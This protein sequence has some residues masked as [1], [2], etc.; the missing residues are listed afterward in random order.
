MSAEIP[1]FDIVRAVNHGLLPRH[2]LSSRPGRLLQAYVGDYLK[3]EIAAESL[4]RNLPAFSRFLEVAA[5]SNGELV[6]YNNIASEC[7]ISAPSVKEYFEITCDTLIGRFLPAWRKTGKRRRIHAPK[8][9]FFDV[10][11][12]AHLA[13]RGKIEQGSELF[14]RVF[15]QFMINEIH[16]HA[17]YSELFYPRAFWRSASGF[18][19]DC[20]L[21][22]H[23]V[24]VEF[25]STDMIRPRHLKGLRA[26]KEE[27]PVKKAIA[28]SLDPAPRV[29]EDH[30]RVL[31]AGEF[32]R[33]LWQGEVV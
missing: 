26:F 2:Y 30:I 5:L 33:Q 31:P 13:R 21:G 20:V 15:E 1:D 6:N 22:D 27:F 10:G 14:G 18:E 28:V 4:T 32:L 3:E 12:T 11:V 17:H 24:A 25:N 7:G 29:T 8:F 23:E 16:A 9:Y 19:V